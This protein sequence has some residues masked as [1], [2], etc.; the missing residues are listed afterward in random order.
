MVT[1]KENT[2]GRII[3]HSYRTPGSPS[4]SLLRPSL[5]INCPWQKA[6]IFH[7]KVERELSA[8]KREFYL[9][10]CDVVGRILYHKIKRGTLSPFILVAMVTKP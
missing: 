3:R 4:N 1:E 7:I 6:A 8:W 2:R 5:N 9:L 10:L